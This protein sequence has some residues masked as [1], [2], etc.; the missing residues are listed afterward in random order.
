MEVMVVLSIIAIIS[1]ISIPNMI[2]WR[3]KK[4][5]Y[6]AANNLAADLQLARISAIRQS[7]SV[8][9]IFNAGSVSSYSM[10]IDK[11]GDWTQDADD[12]LLRNIEAQAGI[13]LKS[14][15]FSGNHT[16]FNTK[17]MPSVTG[18]VVFEDSS[19][20]SLS[21]VVNSVGRIRIDES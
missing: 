3:E 13:T 7:E 2:G 17:G 11:N 1:A 4:K 10:F 12:N 18:T 15:T 14:T 19:G 5:L 6:G 9:V 20:K 21:V 8:A 16:H